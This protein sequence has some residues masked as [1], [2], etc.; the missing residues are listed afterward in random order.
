MPPA[1]PKTYRLPIET[2]QRMA[3]LSKRW[4]GIQ[5]A[6]STAVLV[7]AVNR[8]YLAE[9]GTKGKPKPAKS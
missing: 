1:I 9:F 8:A 7:E 4:G 3:A 6:T 2:I 5:P